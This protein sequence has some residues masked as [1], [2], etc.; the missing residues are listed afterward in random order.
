MS[1]SQRQTAGLTLIEM[2]ITVTIISIMLV[3][4]VPSFSALRQRAALRGAADQL[5][6]VWN[7]A[8]FEAVKRDQMVKV[9]IETG[10]DGAFCIGAATTS[11]AADTAPCD[12]MSAAPASNVCDVARY[13]GDQSEW[14]KVS[15]VGVTI[16]G[17]TLMSAAQPVVIEPKRSSL[18]EPADKGTISLAGPP[19]Q[20][21]YKLNLSID[22]LGH[23]VLCE[24]ATAVSKLPEYSSRHCAD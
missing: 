19:G 5:L 17:T 22:Q 16:G 18:T 3:I 8:R 21:F 2:M 10:A 1:S 24:S 12:C 6:S 15:L 13:P 11:D 14:R 9:G 4:A 7:L 20:N 23:G